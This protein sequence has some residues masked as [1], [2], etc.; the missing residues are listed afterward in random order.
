MSQQ[1]TSSSEATPPGISSER[2]LIRPRA[3]AAASLT[4]AMIVRNRFQQLQDALKSGEARLVGRKSC[5]QGME[6]RLAQRAKPTSSM[7]RLLT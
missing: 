6:A 5:D 2:A 7:T 3:P 1:I 4:Y